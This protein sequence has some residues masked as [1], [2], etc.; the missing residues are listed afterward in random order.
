MIIDKPKP[1]GV[2]SGKA[3]KLIINYIAPYVY[4]VS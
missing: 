3:Q 2:E 1:S 4:K